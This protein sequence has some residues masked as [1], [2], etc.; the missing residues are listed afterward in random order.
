M[1]LQILRYL[2]PTVISSQQI[3][4]AFSIPFYFHFHENQTIFAFGDIKLD[5]HYLMEE[6][7]AQAMECLAANQECYR[8][9]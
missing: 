1:M 8:A 7:G 2:R 6:P 4:V 3:H 5:L 9:D